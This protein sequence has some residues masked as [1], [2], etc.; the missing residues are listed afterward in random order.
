MLELKQDP[1][2]LKTELAAVSGNENKNKNQHN[3]GVLA[4]ALYICESKRGV[5][6]SDT[7]SIILQILTPAEEM[8]MIGNKHLRAS[9]L[10]GHQPY[11]NSL[12]QKGNN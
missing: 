4:L 11:I 10:Q 2:F 5:L 3:C 6:D 7:W 12:H 1:V 8:L 9:Q